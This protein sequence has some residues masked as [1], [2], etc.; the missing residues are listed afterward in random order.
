MKTRYMLRK[1]LEET[2]SEET[3]IS[4]D[5]VSVFDNQIYFIIDFQIKCFEIQY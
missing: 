2:D 4:S 1:Q 3:E 5:E